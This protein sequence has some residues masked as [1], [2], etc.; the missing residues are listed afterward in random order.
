[1]TTAS[2]LGDHQDAQRRVLDGFSLELTARDA[3]RLH[4]LKGIVS[5]RAIMS[6]PHLPSQESDAR[7]GAARMIRNMGYE[8][9]P[10]VAARRFESAM[11]LESFLAELA[12]QAQVES[13]L[14]LAGDIERP[15][16][17]FPD[18]STLLRS[19]LMEKYGVR[20]IAIAGHPEGHPRL[21]KVNLAAALR[22]KQAV[23]ADSG[24]D[25][26]IIT[27]FAFGAEPVLSWIEAV[28][29][30]GIEAPIRIGVPGPANVSTLMRFAA[31]CGVGAS[32]SVLMKYGLS[33]RQLLS[34]AGPDKLIDDYSQL[35]DRAVHG[36]TY[37]HFYPFGGIAKTAEWLD[38]YRAR[39]V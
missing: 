1:M 20:H 23:L 22:E 27:Q 2:I 13:L 28:R 11:E 32:T 39:F 3:H 31:V 17:P 7:V 15:L 35:I 33:L 5:E 34:S 29:R 25:C 18:T 36:E 9:V 19:G 14:V 30:N 37:I 38:K 6:I 26:S 8:P 24:I 21:E 4:L 10:H 12:E 16:G